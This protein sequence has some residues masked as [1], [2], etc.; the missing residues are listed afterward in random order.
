VTHKKSRSDRRYKGMPSGSA[1]GS[2][3]YLD[4]LLYG[5]DY[6]FYGWRVMKLPP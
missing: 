6:R 3:K 2:Q 1:E 5:T 4:R